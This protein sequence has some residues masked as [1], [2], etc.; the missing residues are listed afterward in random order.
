LKR[1]NGVRVVIHCASSSYNK[2]TTDRPIWRKCTYS[3]L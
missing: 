3:S 1:A 2:V